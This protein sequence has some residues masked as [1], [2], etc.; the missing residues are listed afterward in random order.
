MLYRI[1]PSRIVKRYEDLDFLYVRK[2][3]IAVGNHR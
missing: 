3:C 1:I 2:P